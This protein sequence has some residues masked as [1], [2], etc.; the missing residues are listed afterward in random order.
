MSRRHGDCTGWYIYSG[1]VVVAWSGDVVFSLVA[2]FPKVNQGESS[3][4]RSSQHK[5]P[6]PWDFVFIKL[7]PTCS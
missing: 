7:S 1:D 5:G 2:S 3:P 4:M 6:T